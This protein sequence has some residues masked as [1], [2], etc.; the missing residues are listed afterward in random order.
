MATTKRIQYNEGPANIT[1]GAAGRFARDVSREIDSSFADAILTKK[2]ITF[3]EVGSTG[4]PIEPR[5][6]EEGT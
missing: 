5:P 6:E 1:M 3:V 2:S 4:E